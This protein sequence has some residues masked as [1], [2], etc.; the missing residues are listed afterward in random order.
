MPRRAFT[1]RATALLLLSLAGWFLAADG[2]TAASGPIVLQV[3]ATG[4]P[5]RFFHA[6]LS[7]PADAGPMTLLYPKWIAGEHG[8]TGPI[9]DLAGLKISAAG[10]RL[11]WR[12]DDVNMYAFRFDVPA[13]GGGVEVDL[14][15]LSPA[16]AE[17]FSSGAS[18]S[19]RLAVVSWNQLLLY[20]DGAKPGE[21][22]YTASLK[23][24][25]GWKFG[26]ALPVVREG[27]ERI[28]FAAASL[29]TL[30]DSPVLIGSFFRTI[31]LSLE[32]SAP[33]SIH[34]AADGASALSPPAEWEQSLKRLV[35][36]AEA[37]F[38][39]HHYRGYHFLLS[40]SDQ[41]AHFGL[42]HHESSDNRV[43][44]RAFLEPESRERS[45]GLLP[46]EYVHSWNGKYRRPAGLASPDPMEPMKGEMLWV[47]EGLTQ[48]LGNVLTARSGLRSAEEYREALAA[49]AADLDHRPGRMWRP[50]ADTAI[51]AQ[52]L[53]GARD[54][55]ERW[56]RSVDFYD[57]GD[58]IWL[59][60]DTIIRRLT[61]GA[62]SMDD[63]CKRFHGPPSGPPAV[64]PYNFDD[65]V[66][67]L[68]DVAANDWRTFLQER[69]DATGEHAPLGGI[70]NGGWRLVYTDV[71]NKHLDN[72]EEVNKNVELSYSIGAKLKDEGLVVDVLPG[73]AA[74]QAGMAPAMKVVA[75]NGKRFTKKV[76]RE[77]IRA[78]KGTTAPLEI[79][80][81][82][83]D[84]FRTLRLDYH[85]G[86]RYPHLQR[87]EAKPDLL[88]RIIEPLASKPSK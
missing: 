6:H 43:G 79:L 87:D 9:A 5:R 45:G 88:G 65:V 18:A 74:A 75:I 85:D 30:M 35:A 29:T 80:V 70:E 42:E 28:E 54:G 38:G 77:A 59:E 47:Y 15:F 52:I 12:R 86:E 81:E 68:N 10:R 72:D 36:E 19:D 73:S 56:R 37:L 8:P 57:E 50:L 53:F 63:F 11:T 39:A 49:S 64:R 44:E 83:G 21:L 3:D 82:N 26:T 34:M 62:R 60:A 13:G 4:A 16:V 17:G 20:P 48:Y 69:L 7:I 61:K 14:D 46:H 24:P 84:W 78:A 41:I 2:L 32:G 27:P 67:T 25:E 23:V 51:E 31:D 76:L 22:S 1:P 55:W 71:R 66:T 58:L 33:V 40:M